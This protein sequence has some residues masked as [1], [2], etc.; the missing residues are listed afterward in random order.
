MALVHNPSAAIWHEPPQ[1]SPEQLAITE[2]PLVSAIL[3]A[4]GITTEEE[5]HHFLRPADVPLGDPYLLPDMDRA[6]A[7]IR[8]AIADGASIG[9]FGDY[10]VDGLSS[11]AMLVRA[12]SRLGAETMPVIPHR[13]KDGYGLNV[14][15]IERFLDAG[16]RLVVVADCGSANKREL[17][18][19][20]SRGLQ[21]IVLDHH[22]LHG[23]LPET[24]PFVSPRRECSRYPESELAA[25]GVAFALLRAL[26]GEQDAEMY[27][28]YVALGTVADVVQLR[29]ENRTLAARGIEMLRR[30]RLPGLSSLCTVASIDKRELDAFDIGFIIGPRINAAGRMDS[31]D[32]ALNW[33]LAND[34]ATAGLLAHQL[35]DLN[36]I[37][38]SETQRVL[39][40]SQT[41]IEEMGGVAR[42]PALVVA[43]P[44]W[45]IGVAG[46][47][48]GK[49]AEQYHRPAIVFEQGSQIS[50]GS[51][52]SNGTVDMVEA[53]RRN[54]S[55]LDR[56]GGHSAAAGLSIQSD[57]ID[58]FRQA[59]TESVLELW[60]GKI[61]QP[62]LRL[63]AEVRHDDLTLDVVEQL[64]VLEPCGFGNEPPRLLIRDLV[65]AGVRLS[66]NGRHV[67]LRLKDRNGTYHDGVFFGG[68]ERFADLF[69]ARLIDVAGSIRNDTWRGRA[70]LQIRIEDFRATR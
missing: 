13:V 41:Q 6:V 57:R 2:R 53:L 55:L 16:V 31:P 58:D 36:T 34:L 11:T 43:D 44:S 35:N 26:L 30:W 37:R 19:A 25:V 42:Q 40:E 33:F 27:L 32:I 48:A 51:A 38:R 5:A 17:E 21:A 18:F 46:I 63:D 39:E 52:R 4:R 49:L 59:L 70:R 24:V 50:K 56:F 61:P 10:D 7:L 64:K 3:H 45:S 65:P 62:E 22:R 66:R 12:L 23:E 54:A 8:Q 47:V 67:L 68:G 69:D 20:L 29:G 1:L 28:P 14:D 15:A 60:G 9:I